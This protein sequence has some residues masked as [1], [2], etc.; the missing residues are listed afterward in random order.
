MSKLVQIETEKGITTYTGIFY[1]P[2]YNSAVFERQHHQ[3]C[4]PT[5]LRVILNSLGIFDLYG[6]PITKNRRFL[7]FIQR[8]GL[9]DVA[10]DGMY[11]EQVKDLIRRYDELRS[12]ISALTIRADPL[13][14]ARSIIQGGCVLGNVEVRGFYNLPNISEEKL[15]SIAILGVNVPTPNSLDPI[16]FYTFDPNTKGPVWY[17]SESIFPHL[18]DTQ[19]E[20]KRIIPPEL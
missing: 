15:H 20:L 5:S 19:V 2:Y 3:D 10:Q 8:F 14:W 6:I 16:S 11:P 7:A 13:T 4:V 9:I 1:P 18:R 17:P 12:K